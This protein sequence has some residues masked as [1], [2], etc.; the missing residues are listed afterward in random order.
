ME[1]STYRLVFHWRGQTTKKS[2]LGPPGQGQQLS[3]IVAPSS[4][5]AQEK[6]TLEEALDLMQA[7]LADGGFIFIDSF[8]PD[9]TL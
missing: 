7:A 6:E 2:L 4:H 8:E 9:Q 5:A 1:T 3:A